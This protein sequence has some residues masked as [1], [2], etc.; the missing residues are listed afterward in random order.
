M[1][2]ANLLT[3][4]TQ[5]GS[6][7]VSG[8][9]DIVPLINDLLSLPFSLKIATKDYHPQGHISFDTSHDPPNNT[10]FKSQVTITNPF[11]PSETKKITLWPVHCVQGMPGADLIPELDTSKFQVI[12]EKGR[13]KR[14]EMYSGF[15]DVF[16]NRSDAANVDLAALLRCH[17]ISHLYTVGLTGEYCVKYTAID[18]RREGFEV[19]VIEEGTRC[20]DNGE[21]GWGAAKQELHQAGV[22]VISIKDPQVDKVKNLG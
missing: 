14:V 2:F 8:G 17:A 6:L 7:A 19:Y 11:N 18:A 21:G 10:A 13:D 1:V 22:Q 9:R 12:V 5:H 20:V 16:G 4:D 3:R 15:Q